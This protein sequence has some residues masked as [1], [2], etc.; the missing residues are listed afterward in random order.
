M[1]GKRRRERIGRSKRPATVKAAIEAKAGRDKK[2][3][4]DKDPK[5]TGPQPPALH[6]E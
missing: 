2:P 1:P 5:K 4:S 3:D 6:L